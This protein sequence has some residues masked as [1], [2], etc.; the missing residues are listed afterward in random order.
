MGGG[1]RACCRSLAA[2][3]ALVARGL[4]GAPRALNR[5]L[6]RPHATVEMPED[7]RYR[8]R[9]VDDTTAAAKNGSLQAML[10]E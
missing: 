5:H 6:D 3:I 9:V 10:A 2:E 8:G 7:V 4:L 1:R